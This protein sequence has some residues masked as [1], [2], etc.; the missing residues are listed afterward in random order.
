MVPGSLPRPFVSNP[1][2]HSSSSLQTCDIA[3]HSHFGKTQAQPLR[4]SVPSCPGHMDKDLDQLISETLTSHG[5]A[6]SSSSG[7]SGPDATPVVPL[8]ATVVPHM[9][10]IA[11]DRIGSKRYVLT[12]LV[13]NERY[14]ISGGDFELQFHD[15]WGC[16]VGTVGLGEDKVVCVEDA[17]KY[18]LY[19][20]DSGEYVIAAGEGGSTTMV[21]LSEFRGKFTAHQLKVNVGASLA[22]KVLEILVYK[23]PRSPAARIMFCT[24]SLYDAMGLSQFSG[25]SWRWISGSWKRWQACMRGDFE[26]DEHVLHSTLMKEPL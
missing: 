25:E 4:R 5:P 1:V 24:K 19:A 8:V 16:I 9:G 20:T 22:G 21:K 3:M 13:T 23:W 2:G 12:H 6:S 26:M 11:L 18:R 17:L 15:G 14:E 7:G 10:M